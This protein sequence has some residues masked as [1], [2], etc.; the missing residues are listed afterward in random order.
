[1]PP[2]FTGSHLFPRD[3]NVSSQPF[4]TPFG[5]STSI[6]LQQ[7]NLRMETGAHDG[8]GLLV[9]SPEEACIVFY[10][11][12][13]NGECVSRTPTWRKGQNHLMLDLSDHSR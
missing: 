10:S 12:P 13:Y 5:S 2:R 3:I 6:P 11:V 9:E 1:M 8:R 4:T 7:L